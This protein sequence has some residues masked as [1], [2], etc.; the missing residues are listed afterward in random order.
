ML[1]SQIIPPSPSPR[2]QKSYS[3]Q[4]KMQHNTA[5]LEDSLVFPTK[6]SICLTYNQAIVLVGIYPKK[7][8]LK[9]IKNNLY[10]NICER[11]IHNCENLE[12]TKRSFSR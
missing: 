5:T 3:L 10:T 1:F 6:P 4:V 12:A 11:L 8:K 9:S 2:V 7:L